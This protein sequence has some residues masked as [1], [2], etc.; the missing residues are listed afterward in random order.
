MSDGAFRC[1]NAQQ[2]VAAD[3]IPTLFCTDW[4]GVSAGVA[5]MS[6]PAPGRSKGTNPRVSDLLTWVPS[7]AGE[8]QLTGLF[9]PKMS[10]LLREMFSVVLSV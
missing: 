3:R 9:V 2:K 5:V 1:C 7:C 10:I 8:N 6:L 4:R